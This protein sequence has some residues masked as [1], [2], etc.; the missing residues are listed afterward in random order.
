MRR[1]S[2]PAQVLEG[3]TVMLSPPFGDFHIAHA[4]KKW[5]ND[6]VA[7]RRPVACRRGDASIDER[8]AKT[9]RAQAAPVVLLSGRVG[10]T[11]TLSMLASVQAGA[12]PVVWLHAAE[13]S[14]DHPFKEYLRGLGRALEA[15]N[16]SVTRSG[17]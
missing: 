9:R 11:P 5:I 8:L 13:N 17:K 14:L 4:E 7:N 15:E 16:K 1:R 2:L 12:R 6:E 3:D 10:I